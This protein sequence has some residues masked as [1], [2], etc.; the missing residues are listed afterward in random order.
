MKRTLT[1]LPLV[2]VLFVCASP[3]HAK[4]KKEEQSTGTYGVARFDVNQNGI[5]EPEELDAIRKAFA[6]G[7]PA[8]KLLD[9]NNDGKLDDKELAAIKPP[10]P[11]KK[12][13]GDS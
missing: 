4:G 5:F 2:A 6:E 13:K 1:L 7:D 11:K 3:S 12:K 8:I 9:T 10:T